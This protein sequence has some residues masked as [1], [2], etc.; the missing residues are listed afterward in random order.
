MNSA[1]TSLKTAAVCMALSAIVLLSIF[2]AAENFS[3]PNKDSSPKFFVGVE[4]GWNANV[5]QCEAVIDKVKSYTN[6]IIL[7]SPVLAVDAAALNETCDYAFHAGMYIMVYFSMQIVPDTISTSNDS[8]ALNENITAILTNVSYH[9]FLWMIGAE[10]RYGNHFLGIYFHDEPGGTVL[11][12]A[13]PILSGEQA[14]YTTLANGFVQ[15][16]SQRMN[17]LRPIAHH[18][19]VNMFTSDYGLYWFD[20][21]AGFDVVMAQ[22]G[23]NNSRPLQIALTRGAGNVQGKEWGAIVTWTTEQPPYLEGSSQLYQD[24]V[25]AFE[26]GAKYT[27]VYDASKDFLNTTLTQDHYDALKDFW[28]YVQANPNKQGSLKADTALAL[29]QDYGFGFRS[30]NDSV[31]GVKPDNMTEQVYQDVQS[32]LSEY[33]S[34][35]DLVYNEAAF[36]STTTSKYDKIIDLT[37]G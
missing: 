12:S 28:N 25:L 15:D 27:A 9:P 29:P 17:I 8:A 1:M 18:I 6:L 22:F 14:N 3:L 7:A 4:I 35:L 23:W 20:Y 24:L 31:W 19:G 16:T 30:V 33:G 37:R 13:T 21:K 2:F 5:S 36:N 10:E 11:D 34:R 32:F 26:S